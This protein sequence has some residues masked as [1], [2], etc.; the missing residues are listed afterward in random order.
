MAEKN[1]EVGDPRIVD[2]TERNAATSFR[3]N[4]GGEPSE[5]PANNGRPNDIKVLD[6]EWAVENS[7]FA[8]RAKQAAKRAKQ[9]AADEVEDKAVSSAATKR[10]AKKK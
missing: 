6:H 9:V 3:D 5:A 2:R 1:D 7:T 8:G 4:G 10:T